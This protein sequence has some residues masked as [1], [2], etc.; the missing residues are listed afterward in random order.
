MVLR[1][2]WSHPSN[3]FGFVAVGFSHVILLSTPDVLSDIDF[4]LVEFNSCF[5]SLCYHHQHRP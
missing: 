4:L 1:P 2:D 5:N 3:S